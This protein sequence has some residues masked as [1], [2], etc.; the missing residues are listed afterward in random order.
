MSDLMKKDLEIFQTILNRKYTLLRN[1][2]TS[3]VD[4]I[5]VDANSI[6]LEIEKEFDN[7]TDLAL[8]L[9][10]LPSPDDNDECECYL[11]YNSKYN[12]RIY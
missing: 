5:K 2:P 8:D 3:K 6:M 11:S 1:V 4:S 10:F 7:A 9:I 12:F